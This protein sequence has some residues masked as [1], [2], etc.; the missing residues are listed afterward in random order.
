MARLAK[1]AP[2]YRYARSTLA[3]YQVMKALL[4]G[5][6]D[7]AEQRIEE[8]QELVRRMQDPFA[9]NNLAPAAYLLRREQGRL[10]ELEPGLR[11]WAEQYPRIPAWRCALAHLF[12]ELGRNQEARREFEAL[13]ASEFAVLPRTDSSG[14]LPC[15]SSPR[16]AWSSRTSLAPRSSTG[17]SN[18]TLASTP[19]RDMRQSS[20]GSVARPLGSLA[21]LLRRFEEAERHFETALEIHRRMGALPWLAYTQHDFARMLLARG[22][23]AIAGGPSSSPETPSPLRVSSAWSP[24]QSGQR[25]CSRKSRARSHCADAARSS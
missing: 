24:W 7:D 5:R 6:F 16:S 11:A 21:G 17:C 19:W 4:T 2:W 12:A 23:A 18:Q 15:R 20:S 13:A 8:A 10:S 22:E 14:S 3:E 9:F 25:R 1:D